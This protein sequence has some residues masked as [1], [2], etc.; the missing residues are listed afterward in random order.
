[1]KIAAILKF[2]ALD[3]PG[4]LS[5][6]VFCQGCPLRCVYCHNQDFLDSSLSGNVSREEFL[7]FLKT[8]VGL[9]EAIVFSGGEPLLQPN[10]R[11]AIESVKELGYAVGIHTSGVIP[12]ALKVILPT[13]DW[14]GLDIKTCF[15]SYKDITN[16]ADSGKLVAESLSIILA[17]WV[18]YE[19]RTTYDSR[20]I[21][22]ADLISIAQSLGERGVRRWIIQECI[23]RDDTRLT[24]LP[25]PSQDILSKIATY[26]NVELRRS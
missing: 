7:S 2:S 4:K 10:L 5:A 11:E 25:L 18:N 23:I 1:M 15:E 9:L 24:H 16:V 19:I 13:L 8:R 20:N 26:V 6:V 3:Y 14:V 12:N 22:D 17:S 21:T